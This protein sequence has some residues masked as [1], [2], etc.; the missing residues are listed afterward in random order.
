MTKVILTISLFL[1]LLSCSDKKLNYET[2]KKT[3]DYTVPVFIDDFKNKTAL[4]IFPHPDDEIVCGGAI[5]EL[6]NKGWTINILTLT[7]G[8]EGEKQTRKKEWESAVKLLK[9]DN[10][11]ILDLPNNKWDDVITNNITFWYDNHDSLENII[12]HY[13][14][15][16][17]PSLLFTYD[18]TLGAYGHPEHRLSA[19]AAKNVF[20]KHRTDSLFTVKSIFQI[21]LPEKMEQL[22]L[23][24]AES[25]KNAIKLTGNKSLPEPTVAFNIKSNWKTKRKAASAYVSQTSTLEKFY[26]LPAI[27]DTTEHYNTFDR[28]YYFEVK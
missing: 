17:K 18:T 22:M 9:F 10:Y 26:L 20:E 7:Q 24:N 13:I 8:V 21:T 3:Q 12:E 11:N 25:Y 15:K 16:H 23:G 6:K 14:S 19:L 28:E 5:A 27:N 2:F 4:F 1:F